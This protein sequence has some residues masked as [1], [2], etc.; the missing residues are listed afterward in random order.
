MCPQHLCW[1]QHFFTTLTNDFQEAL[2]CVHSSCRCAT[3]VSIWLVYLPW[4]LQFAVHMDQS[5]AKNCLIHAQFYSFKESTKQNKQSRRLQWSQEF[6]KTQ[7]VYLQCPGFLAQFFRELEHF[8][9]LIL[10]YTGSWLPYLDSWTIVYLIT[11]SH[12]SHLAFC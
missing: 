4:Y 2:C 9:T 10:I 11:N 3:T 5:I 6:H 12:P 7:M 1:Q 8:C